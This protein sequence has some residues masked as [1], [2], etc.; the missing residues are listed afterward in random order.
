MN[1]W[2][3]GRRFLET[4]AAKSPDVFT[5]SLLTMGMSTALMVEV[6]L[7]GNLPSRAVAKRIFSRVSVV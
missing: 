1:V 7:L 5:V 3:A 2:F 6:T 4:A